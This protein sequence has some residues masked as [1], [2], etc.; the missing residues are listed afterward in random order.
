[1]KPPFS[2]IVILGAC[3]SGSA[4][5]QYGYTPPVPPTP[6]TMPNAPSY[7]ATTSYTP[8]AGAGMDAGYGYAAP[9]T[10]YG[11]PT[12]GGY[13]PQPMAGST[14]VGM[15]IG[16]SLL[17][18]GYLEGFYQYTNFKD[19]SLDP[20]NGF[21]LALSAQLFN[22]FY[23]KAGF[24][25]GASN[26]GSKEAHGYDFS[27]VSIGAGAYIPINARF[28]LFC[29]IGGAYY[30]VDADKESVGFSEGAIYVHPGVRIAATESIEL[31][32]GL[33]FTSADSYDSIVFDVGAYWKM[34]SALDLKV[35]ADIGDESTAWKAGLR[36]RW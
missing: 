7:P 26:G 13:S 17:S 5:A 32:G 16:A 36:V 31:Q 24:N 15:G 8:P 21:G 14:P 4:F 34:F 29:D 9:E 33:M 28:H 1:M 19:S 3:W 10:T 20:A 12:Y 35:G 6:P 27:S 30:K 18:Y 22:P 23:I 11:S 2:L 25:W